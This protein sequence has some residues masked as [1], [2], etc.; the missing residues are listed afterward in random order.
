MG[1]SGEK[2]E[3]AHPAIKER[4]SGKKEFLMRLNYSVNLDFVQFLASKI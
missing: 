1:V 4:V 3:P 2:V